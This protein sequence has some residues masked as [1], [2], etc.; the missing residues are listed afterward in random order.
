MTEPKS[1]DG[2]VTKDG[3]EYLCVLAERDNRSF[4]L[5]RAGEAFLI[6]P[7]DGSGAERDFESL[8]SLLAGLQSFFLE[9][10]VASAPAKGF[11]E[12][13]AAQDRAKSDVIEASRR[14]YAAIDADR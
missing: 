3:E 1:S 9:F 4:D 2:P 12:L 14:I 13:A 5:F 8:P 7:R 10:R 11:A 6:R